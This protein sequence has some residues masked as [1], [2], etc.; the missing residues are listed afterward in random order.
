MFKKFLSRKLIVIITTAIAD[1]L[2]ATGSADPVLKDLLLKLITGLG[3]LYVIVEGL[4]DAIA[5]LKKQSN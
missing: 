5:A 2:I 3:S 4:K 1:I